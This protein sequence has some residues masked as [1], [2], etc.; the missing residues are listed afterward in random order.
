MS[1][2]REQIEHTRTVKLERGGQ[3]REVP[4]DKLRNPHALTH[5]PGFKPVVQTKDG[6]KGAEGHYS[7]GPEQQQN[8]QS[9]AGGLLQTGG[10]RPTGNSSERTSFQSG[11]RY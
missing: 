4:L 8:H 10:H 1:E 11:R 6:D 5:A 9:S 2:D 3:V 7:R